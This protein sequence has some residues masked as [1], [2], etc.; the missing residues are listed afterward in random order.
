MEP[1]YHGPG[2]TGRHQYDIADAHVKAW[3]AAQQLKNPAY[4]KRRGQTAPPSHRIKSGDAN[5]TYA[6]PAASRS[7]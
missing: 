1:G 4:Y 7:F 5:L 6:P 2:R 3:Q